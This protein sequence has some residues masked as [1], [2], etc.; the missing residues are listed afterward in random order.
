MNEKKQKAWTKKV[1]KRCAHCACL[2]DK[3][4]AWWCD[5]ANEACEKV[6]DCP[7]GLTL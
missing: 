2:V 7:E 1:Q 5:E 4:N 6:R 3:E